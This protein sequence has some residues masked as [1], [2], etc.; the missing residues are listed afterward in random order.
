MKTQRKKKKKTKRRPAP[1]RYKPSKGLERF[2]RSIH[3]ADEF[4]Q[5]VG[6]IARAYQA[7]HA[8]DGAAG[9][10]SV[11]QSLRT[12]ERRATALVQWLEAALDERTK[13]AEHEAL[14]RLSAAVHGSAAAARQPALATLEWLRSAAA[15]SAT[16]ET[17]LRGEQL[18]NA[19]RTAAAALRATF[20]YHKLKLAQ[21]TSTEPYSDAVRLLCVIASD[22]GDDTMTPIIARRWLSQA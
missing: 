21:R 2:A 22:A 16:V 7:Q 6:N 14:N 13:P 17:A 12:F 18:H 11:R 9:S 19:P 5:H 8:L 4:V 3:D 10:R 1:A 20:E 15:C